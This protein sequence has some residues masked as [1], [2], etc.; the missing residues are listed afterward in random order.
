MF[1]I[2]EI[3]FFKRI[4]YKF[5]LG[6]V[7]LV[8]NDVYSESKKVNI[9]LN[10]NKSGVFT[11]GSNLKPVKPKK[12]KK[13]TL[14]Y[15]GR[16]SRE[17]NIEDIILAVKPIKKK[18]KLI[19]VGPIEDKKYY[20]FL[21][22]ISSDLDVE[23]TGFLNKKEI[24]EKFSEADI[25]V[26]LCK[27]EVFGRVFVEALASGL[28]IIG[29][30]SSPGPREIIKDGINGWIVKSHEELTCLLGSLSQKKIKS[31]RKRCI[32]LSKN[33][34]FDNSYKTFKSLLNKLF[35]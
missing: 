22:E 31:V 6:L 32:F 26:N 30:W 1:K 21:R 9:F 28:P 14:I 17:K 11:Y 16:I 23:F 27:K 10:K 2:K 5:Y 4:F 34:S 20:N 8:V 12:H 7:D 13:L 15:V 35:G 18:I 29:H 24:Q 25:F 19:V 33:Y 3:N